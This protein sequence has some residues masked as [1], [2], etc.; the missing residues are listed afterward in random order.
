MS[1]R[2]VVLLLLLASFGASFAA[3]QNSVPAAA[4]VDNDFVHQQFGDS[5]SLE[6]KWQPMKGD[7]NGDGSEDIVIVA[8]C[9]NVLIDQGEK[10]YLVVDPMDSF[11]G[12]GNPSI[13]TSFAPDDPKLRGVSLLVIHG[14]GADG[15][16][17]ATPLAKFVIINLPVKTLTVKKMKVKRKKLATAIYVEEAGADQMTAAIFWDGK[18]YRYQPLGSSME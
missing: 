12:Y 15:W 6:P 7:L 10:N 9:K 14:D 4:L 16:R 13:T 11:F 1:S 3:A 17:A 2:I 18:K 8:R 5:C